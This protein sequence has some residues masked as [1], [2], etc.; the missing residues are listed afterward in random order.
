[1]ATTTVPTYTGNTAANIHASSTIAA[2]GTAND[3][4]DG[5]AVFEALGTEV[6]A[7]ATGIKTK[8]LKTAVTTPGVKLRDPR[9]PREFRAQA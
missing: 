7:R 3:N 5:S 8:L 9:T 1:M 6:P 4:Y 2:S